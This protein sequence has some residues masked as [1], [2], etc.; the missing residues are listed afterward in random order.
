MTEFRIQISEFRKTYG[1]PVR[2]S[3]SSF[4]N[5]EICILNSVIFAV[6]PFHDAAGTASRWSA[7]HTSRARTSSSSGVPVLSMR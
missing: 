7:C 3:P 1:K 2:G 6:L 4:L 5:S